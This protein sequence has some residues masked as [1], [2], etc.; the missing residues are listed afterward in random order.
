MQIP[1]RAQISQIL[2]AAVTASLFL[3]PAL[4]A[5]QSQ[6]A[7]PALP[8]AQ[9]SPAQVSPTPAAPPSDAA[10]S[11]TPTPASL[12]A[13]PAQIT[14]A[15]GVLTI[16]ASNSSL[17]QILKDVSRLA[18]VTVNG[19]IADERVFG[20]YGPGKTGEV[21]HML[22][23]GSSCNMFFV[24]GATGKSSE[25]TLTPRTAGSPDT[26]STSYTQPIQ[27][28]PQ[29]VQSQPLPPRPGPPFPNGPKTQQQ[30]YQELQQAHQQADQQAAQPTDQQTD[31]QPAQQDA[32]T[33]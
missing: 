1:N 29:P 33:Q 10:A 2:G 18:G 23:D 25:L 14:F 32:N 24:Q 3:L 22:L 11:T 13:L 31:Q 4:A 6:P 26:G 8:A 20:V 9:A 21:L 7:K 15:N 12:P 30:I 5:A 17:N 19:T 28:Q 16:T 27:N